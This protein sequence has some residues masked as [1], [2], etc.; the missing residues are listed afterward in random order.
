MKKQRKI[1]IAAEEEQL[2]YYERMDT[3]MC[4]LDKR[5]F[6]CLHN[7]IINL[8]KVERMENQT[9]F[10][11]NG[12]QFSLGRDNYVRAK[13]YYIAYLKKLL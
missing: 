4:Y 3:V 13:Q 1:L 7:F 9:I 11:L 5:F 8:D 2:E 10:F 12:E 6:P